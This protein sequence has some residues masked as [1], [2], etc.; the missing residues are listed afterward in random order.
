MLVQECTPREAALD[1]RP[2]FVY[3]RRGSRTREAKI[4]YVIDLF[5]RQHRRRAR[6]RGRLVPDAQGRL[7][8][9]VEQDVAVRRGERLFWGAGGGGGVVAGWWVVGE[10]G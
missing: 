1:F 10:D 8:S 9:A 5:G 2:A 4:D 6:L 7:A 3:V